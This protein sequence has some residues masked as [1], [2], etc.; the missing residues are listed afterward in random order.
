MTDLERVARAIAD[1]GGVGDDYVDVPIDEIF[2]RQRYIGQKGRV[3]RLA[4]AALSALREPSEGMLEASYKATTTVS[5]EDRMATEL[6][7]RAAQR[8]AIK[9]RRRWQA[10]IDFILSEKE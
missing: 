5:A 9:M 2:T 3:E 8:H 4:R 1:A 6:E 7:P 10:A